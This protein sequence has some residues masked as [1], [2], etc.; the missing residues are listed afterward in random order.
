MPACRPV[1]LAVQLSASLSVYPSIHLARVF[2]QLER[3]AVL[4]AILMSW[5][6][7]CDIAAAAITLYCME[8]CQR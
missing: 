6:D 8:G 7:G 3:P 1:G 2:V 4:R 5:P